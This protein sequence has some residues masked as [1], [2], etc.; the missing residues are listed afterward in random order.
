[1]IQYPQMFFRARGIRVHSSKANP[2]AYLGNSIAT[3]AA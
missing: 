2:G 1:M 3:V